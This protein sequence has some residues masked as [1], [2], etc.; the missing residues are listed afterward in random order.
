MRIIPSRIVCIRYCNFKQKIKLVKE[1]SMR[2][3]KVEIIDNNFVY[4]EL[5][6]EDKYAV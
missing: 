5:R 6:K 2:G 1:Y 3:Y 4:A